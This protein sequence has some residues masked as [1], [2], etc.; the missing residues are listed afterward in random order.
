MLSLMYKGPLRDITHFADDSNALTN[1]YIKAYQMQNNH[2]DARQT[3]FHLQHVLSK[4]VF[5]VLD[6]CAMP[7]ATSTLPYANQDS[8]SNY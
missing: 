1:K 3:G 8:L 2:F 6:I 5:R 7:P 4:Y